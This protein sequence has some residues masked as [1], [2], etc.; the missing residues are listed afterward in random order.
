MNTTISN[1]AIT[2]ET[3]IPT[4]KFTSSRLYK[5]VMAWIIRFLH[6]CKAKTQGSQPKGVPLNTQELNQAAVLLILSHPSNPF[7]QRVENPEG[8][9]LEDSDLK[10]VMLSHTYH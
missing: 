1:V 6:N 5:R 10:Q 3:L 8:K 2:E 7:P 4:D 9:I